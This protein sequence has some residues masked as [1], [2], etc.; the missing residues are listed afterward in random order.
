MQDL[1]RLK[2]AEEWRATGAGGEAMQVRMTGLGSLPSYVPAC[3]CVQYC[4]VC[5]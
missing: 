5:Q 2:D 4:M 3:L 1:Y